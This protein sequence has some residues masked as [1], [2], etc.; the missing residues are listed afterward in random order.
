MLEQFDNRDSGHAIMNVKSLTTLIAAVDFGSFQNAAHKLGMSVSNVSV[1]IKNLE[2]EMGILLFDRSHRP[3]VPTDEGRLFIA[4]AREVVAHWQA[5][6]ESLVQPMKQKNLRLGTVH[7]PV[8]GALPPALQQLQK[9]SGPVD[10]RL[11]TDLSIELEDQ[12]QRKLLDC[13]LVSQ[14]ERLGDN[15]IYH[16]LALEPLMLIVPHS[17]TGD[18]IETILNCQ[19]YV[20]F[21]RRARV[22]NLIDTELQRRNIIVNSAMGS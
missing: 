15:L 10:I 7:T 12:L 4:R 19:P 1:H 17:I 13:I 14:P 2:Q 11:V 18:T 5:L 16:P 6:H 21:N 9:I 22:A 8:A 3:P 20:R